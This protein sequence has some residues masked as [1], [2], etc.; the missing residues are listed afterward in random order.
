ML[1]QQAEEAGIIAWSAQSI[2]RHNMRGDFN[3]GFNGILHGMEDRIL[4]FAV[5]PKV[6]ACNVPE[7]V[8]VARITTDSVDPVYHFI[9]INNHS[10]SPAA[11]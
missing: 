1:F 7:V 11:K 9:P 4:S 6:G 5:T 8:Q 2:S 10:H 3:T